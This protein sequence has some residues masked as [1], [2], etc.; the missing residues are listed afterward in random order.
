MSTTLD[1]APRTPAPRSPNP[2]AAS[3]TRIGAVVLKEFRHLR[4]DCLVWQC[5]ACDAWIFTSSRPQ[6][7]VLRC[8]T[9]G[10]GGIDF[11]HADRH[12]GGDD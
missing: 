3:L 11:R 6:V 8:S 2:V 10:D 12:V 4:R 1:R 9:C 5:G 7:G